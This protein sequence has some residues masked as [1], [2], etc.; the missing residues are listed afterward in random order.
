M[1]QEKHDTLVHL[2]EFSRTDYEQYEGKEDYRGLEFIFTD[3]FRTRVVI[4]E[5]DD[6]LDVARYLIEM[7]SAILAS[8]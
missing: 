7:A 1:V 5:T 4:K 2:R 3:G 6:K 8:R